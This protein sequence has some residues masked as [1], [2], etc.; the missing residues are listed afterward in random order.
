MDT[1]LD[2]YRKHHLPSK[3]SAKA[4]IKMTIK[5]YSQMESISLEK[6]LSIT[7]RGLYVAGFSKEEASSIVKEAK[8]EMGL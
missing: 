6:Q 3:E 1:V 2:N 7:E 4:H 5:N 8:E